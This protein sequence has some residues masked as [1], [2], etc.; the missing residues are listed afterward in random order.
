MTVS[1]FGT[2]TIQPRWPHIENKAAMTTTIAKPGAVFEREGKRR[3]FVRLIPSNRFTSAEVEWRR[4]GQ[5]MRSSACS[6][7]AWIKWVKEAR[8]IS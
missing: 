4:P 3:E 8:Q 2:R 7:H 5:E 1:F 6:L